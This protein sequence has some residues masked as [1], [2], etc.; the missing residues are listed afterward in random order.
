MQKTF[1]AAKLARKAAFDTVV[2]QESTEADN[3]S[4]W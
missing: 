3:V 1:K 4:E 2:D